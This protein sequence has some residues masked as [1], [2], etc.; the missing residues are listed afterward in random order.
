MSESW[1]QVFHCE[2]FYIWTHRF[3]WQ[4]QMFQRV[5]HVWSLRISQACII[6]WSLL[7][8]PLDCWITLTSDVGYFT[9]NLFL[10]H[11]FSFPLIVFPPPSL[12][13][14]LPSLLCPWRRNWCNRNRCKN[15]TL[16]LSYALYHNSEIN[17]KLPILQIGKQIQSCWETSLR[18]HGH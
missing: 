1:E 5:S 12:P 18:S 10:P 11:T 15:S 13:P 17:D 6:H 4:F 8:P 2:N 9:C 16:Y 7:L 14:L 3:L